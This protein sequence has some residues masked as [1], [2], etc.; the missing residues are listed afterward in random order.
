MTINVTNNAPFPPTATKR[1]PRTTRFQL[2]STPQTTS[3]M[4]SPGTP[5]LETWGT[6]V[7]CPD[8]RRHVD[9]DVQRHRRHRYRSGAFHYAT[10]PTTHRLPT[11]SLATLANQSLSS[12]VTASDVMDALT[13]QIESPQ[14]AAKQSSA[15]E[16][17]SSIFR[18][19]TTSRVRFLH[20]FSDGRHRSN[21]QSEHIHGTLG[22][23]DA[24]RR[25]RSMKAKRLCSVG[26]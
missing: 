2:T 21:G 18:T 3:P 22:D 6:S 9:P 1:A 16:E 15:P 11:Y 7:R 13:F 26:Q 14:S 25:S 4:P 8:R 17:A 20:I 24:V 19:S 5:I 12:S 10:S 23:D